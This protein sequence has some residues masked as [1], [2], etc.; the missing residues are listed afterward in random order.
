VVL[1]YPHGIRLHEFGIEIPVVPDRSRLVLDAMLS[2]PELSA[3]QESWLLGPDGTSITRDD[4]LRVHSPAYAGRAFGPGVEDVL[5]EVFELLDDEGNYYRYN[6]ANARRPLAELFDD[7]LTWMAGTCQA[8][9]EALER[10]FCYYLG[11]GA[12]H[13]HYDF[14]H[15]FCVFNDIVTAIRRLQA[16]GRV[17]TAWVIDTDA[18]KG[19]GTA[20]LTANDASITTLS[21]HMAHG[22]PLDLP[23]TRNG[24]PAPWLEPSS[25]D[26]PIASGEEADYISRFAAALEELDRLAGG[27]RPD[28]CYVV[29]GADPYEHDELPSTAGLR[30]SL[31]QLLERDQLVHRFLAERSI[32]QAWLLAGGYGRRAWEPF[33]N[34]ISRVVQGSAAAL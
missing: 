7:V 26:V 17:K 15:G 34:F 10:G 23:R 19:D 4:V 30:L 28:V 33:A 31:E 29:S 25:V 16:E 22:W 18:H 11:G 24:A 6:P 27:S 32:P 1:Y 3:R 13:G 8:G 2:D 20:A 9:R 5:L 21:V 12:H 14:G